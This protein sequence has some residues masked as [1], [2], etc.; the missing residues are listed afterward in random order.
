MKRFAHPWLAHPWLSLLI[1]GVWLL[2]QQSLHPAHLVSGALLA[3]LLPRL[4]HRFL[5][6]GRS[7]KKPLVMLRL[8]GLVLWDIVLSNI[9]VA[10]IVLSPKA[11]PQ[12][13][14]VRVPLALKDPAAINL[15]ASIITTTPGTVS[16]VVD[17]VRGVIW[18]HALD[19]SNADEMAAQ[20]KQRY[21]QP[22]LQMFDGDR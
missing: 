18:V 7:P 4:V 16:C 19:C 6:E 9:A 21:E 20:M 13:A 12:P 11:Q 3:L 5:G 15:F 10:R 1:F 17:P 22:L 8:L 14:W 2:L